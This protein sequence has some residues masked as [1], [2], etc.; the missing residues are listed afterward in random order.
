LAYF[1]EPLSVIVFH[2]DHPIDGIEFAV[3]M[4]SV[5]KEVIAL[6]PRMGL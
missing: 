1:E 2:A 4:A 6:L 5:V 3:G